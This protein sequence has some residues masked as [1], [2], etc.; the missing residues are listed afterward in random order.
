MIRG[1]AAGSF[2]SAMLCPLALKILQIVVEAVETFVP[3]AAVVLDPVGGGLEGAGLEPARPPLGL[4]A[5]SDQAGAFEHFEV[6]G[7]AGQADG[8]WL[9]QCLTDASPWASRFRMAR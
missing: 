1:C 6:F 4:A 7:N 3:E 2:R 5:A 8:E 9:R